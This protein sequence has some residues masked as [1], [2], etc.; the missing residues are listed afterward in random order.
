MPDL[1]DLPLSFR[2]LTRPAVVASIAAAGLTL[3]YLIGFALRPEAFTFG[4]VTGWQLAWI[5]LVDQW[6]LECIS[7]GILFAL[8]RGY[9]RW[10]GL[11]SVRLT[12]HG[13]LRYG[14]SFLPVMMA[15]FVVFNPITQS[16][17]FILRHA[18]PYDWNLYL[19]HYLFSAELW[20]LYSTLS[21]VQT[22]VGLAYIIA[23]SYTADATKPAL[24]L[25]THPTITGKRDGSVYPIALAEVQWFEVENRI[26][27]AVTA[28]G[29]F[30]LSTTLRALEAQ[31]GER[32]VRI[33]RSVLVNP[34]HVERFSPWYDGK[35]V[36]HIG[37]TEHTVSRSRVA[38]LKQALGVS[39]A[40]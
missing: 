33:N 8:V 7:V 36:L 17:R 27:Y 32:F 4:G 40:P 1:L 39:P 30:R 3:Y 9:A 35:Y 23:A 18:P 20:M 2:P 21:V 6:A 5:V 19:E 37:R 22:S 29:R 12:P 10:R 31:L 25:H 13:L 28:E 34:A 16:L 14:L 26:Y 24:L 15:A 11:T 38:T